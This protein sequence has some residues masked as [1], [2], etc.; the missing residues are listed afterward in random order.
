MVD[1]IAE[2][3]P[4]G[5]FASNG[6]VDEGREPF[7]VWDGSSFIRLRCA[8]VDLP[9]NQDRVLIHAEP[10]PVPVNVP[11]AEGNCFPPPQTRVG[12]HED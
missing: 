12:Q 6:R 1:P 9:P 2:Q 8:D 5:R 7:G 3:Q 4:V 11:D 10:S